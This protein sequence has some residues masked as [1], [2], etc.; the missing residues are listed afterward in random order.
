MN[1]EHRVKTIEKIVFVSK[2]KLWIVKESYSGD[3]Q[4]AKGKQ[5]MKKKIQD[6]KD[7]KVKHADGLL[8][9][10]RDHIYIV[11]KVYVPDKKK[12]LKPVAK[13]SPVVDESISEKIAQLKKRKEALEAKISENLKFTPLNFKKSAKER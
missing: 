9:E 2:S 4:D 12:I 8:Y 10:R 13:S 7:G 6:I 11:S 1:L 5:R 3:S